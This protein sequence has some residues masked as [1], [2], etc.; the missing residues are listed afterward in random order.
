[1]E[2]VQTME[3]NRVLGNTYTLD[4]G[5]QL[6]PYYKLNEKEI[7]LLDAGLKDRHVNKLEDFLMKNNYVVKGILCT[8]GHVDHIGNVNYL[9]GK[10]ECQVALPEEEYFVIRSLDQLE[11]F[12]SPTPRD[13]VYSRY[14]HMIFRPDVIINKE[15]QEIKL[16]GAT[17]KVIHTPGHSIDHVCYITPDNVSYLGDALLS[18]DMMRHSKLPYSYNLLK[19]LSSK[20]SL[21]HVEASYHILAHKGIYAD[22]K[23]LITDNIYFYKN[24]AEYVLEK[25][26]NP[27][28]FEELFLVIMDDLSI[29]VST[30]NKYR[31]ME[32]ILKS[33]IRYLEETQKIKGVM[34]D[35]LLK[36]QKCSQGV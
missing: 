28:S 22:I 20:M 23:N 31:V 5:G 19:D 6:L 18:D 24:H 16:C 3:E 35:R 7:I 14:G 29:A 11:L 33:Y 4:L 32:R 12:F 26:V 34:V 2:G 17:F 25:L 9:K 30:P 21:Y 13:Q 10:Y 36:Y 1:M 15:D 27:L 8:H